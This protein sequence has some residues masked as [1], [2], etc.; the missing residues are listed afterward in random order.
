M[1]KPGQRNT[2]N[3]LIIKS[4]RIWWRELIVGFFTLIV[5]FYCF[6]VIYFFIDALFSLNHEYPKLF[7]IVFKMTN[8]DIRDFFKIGGML[9][10][11]IY[12]FLSVWS[13]YNRKK[14]GGLTRRKCPSLTTKEDLMSL[15]IIDE[16]VFEKL[17]N[18]KVIV[19]ETNPIRGGEKQ[20]E[21]YF[22]QISKN[23]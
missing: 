9:F 14:Y 19:L 1:D 11:L 2:P 5:W 17:Q 22:K 16:N 15:N 8:I 13:Y 7:K 12:L 3:P 21:S 20:Y 6:T 18:E 4:K 10:I 23:L